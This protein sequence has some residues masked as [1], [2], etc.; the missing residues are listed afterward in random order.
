MEKPI[1]VTQPSLP[2]LE[3]FIPYLEE[4]W[5]NKIL[6]NNGPMHQQLEKELAEFS[7]R[8]IALETD[9]V[10]SHCNPNTRK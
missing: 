4:I 6:T 10:S 1:Y 8:L 2:A 3:E 9:V 7:K 5:E